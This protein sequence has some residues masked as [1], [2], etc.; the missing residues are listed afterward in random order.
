MDSLF[1]MR[2]YVKA[3]ETRSFS[4]AAEAFGLAPSSVSRQVAQ[5][6]KDLGITLLRR[7]TRRL[8]PTEAGLDYHARATRILQ[9]LDEA[10]SAAGDY[11]KQPKGLLRVNACDVFGEMYVAPLIPEFIG[12]NPGIEVDLFMTDQPVDLVETG[13]D[14]AV[15]IGEVSDG[16]LV[17]RRLAPYRRVVCASPAYLRKRGRPGVPAELASHNCLLHV[18]SP[19][20][21]V[22]RVPW[23]RTFHE[24]QVT[25][26][27]RSNSMEAVRAAALAGLGVA[28]LPAWQAA[29]DLS[30]GRLER[31]FGGKGGPAETHIVAVYHKSRHPDRKLRLFMQFLAEHFGRMQSAF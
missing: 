29:E 1:A 27:F 4:K 31:L 28:R 11:G 14:L 7:S 9:L 22:W 18:R 23:R 3:V 25:G 26:N 6:E 24:V 12:A 2:L 16:S 17:A 5:L 20:M 10:S 21:V 8:T 13:T 15:R 19:G 30:A